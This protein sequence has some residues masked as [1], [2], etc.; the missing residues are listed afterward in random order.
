MSA[1]ISKPIF[2]LRLRSDSE[3]DRDAIRH[4]KALLKTLLRKHHFRCVE[5]VQEQ[6]PRA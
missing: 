5:V 6:D 4:L 1:S 2:R 3:S